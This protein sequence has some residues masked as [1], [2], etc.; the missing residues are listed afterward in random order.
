M[1]GKGFTKPPSLSGPGGTAES[2]SED[3]LQGVG[4]GHCG[5]T[6]AALP[7]GAGGGYGGFSIL[8]W[9]LPSS[10]LAMFRA[11]GFLWLLAG[12]LTGR[13]LWKY[14]FSRNMLFALPD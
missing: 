2:W 3:S 6:R 10:L 1:A 13:S 11:G 8:G 5:Q 12:L 14:L 7:L 4:S 9:D